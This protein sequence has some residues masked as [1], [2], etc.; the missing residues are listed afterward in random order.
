MV[1]PAILISGCFFTGAVRDS[2]IAAL[3][4][5]V[6]SINQRLDALEASRSGGSATGSANF[7]TSTVSSYDATPSLASKPLA[8]GGWW[9]AFTWRGAGSK[10]LRGLTNV[11]TGWVEIPKRVNETTNQSGALSGFTWGLA[12]GVGYGFIRTAGGVYEVVT[13][14]FPAP[15]DY[16]P[17]MQ[18]PYVFSREPQADY[19]QAPN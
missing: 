19:Q 13:F 12:R 5:R 7:T 6:Q 3:E 14:P 8:Q 9:A 15:P 16:R 11:V 17:V 10:L 2:D 18:P 1:A 4:T